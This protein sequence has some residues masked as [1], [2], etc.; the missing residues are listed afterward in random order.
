MEPSRVDGSI[1]DK[2]F[3]ITIKHTVLAILVGLLLMSSWSVGQN[4]TEPLRTE[5][6]D[7]SGVEVRLSYYDQR[8]IALADQIKDVVRL[9]FPQ[10]IDLFGGLPE[11]LSRRDYRD[12]TINLRYGPLTA[13]ADPQSLVLIGC[14]PLILLCVNV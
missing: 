8:L 3:Q 5:T 7:V 6:F 12:F 4:Q 11:E 10:A 1:Y 14:G 13:E 2:S 9:A